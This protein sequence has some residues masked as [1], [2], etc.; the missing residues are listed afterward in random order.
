VFSQTTVDFYGCDIVG[1][2][3]ACTD[4][5]LD[6]ATCAIGAT[7][8]IYTG[9]DYTGTDFEAYLASMN[10]Y[11]ADVCVCIQPYLYC[12]MHS[13]YCNNLG[14][15]V[16]A[17]F[18]ANCFGSCFLNTA[19]FTGA[20]CDSFTNRWFFDGSISISETGSVFDATSTVEITGDFYISVDASVTVSAYGYVAAA[21][22]TINGATVIHIDSQLSLDYLPYVTFSTK[23]QD[24]AQKE[25]LIAYGT[26][27]T[28]ADPTNYEITFGTNPC[29]TYDHSIVANETHVVLLLDNYD[30]SACS[31]NYNDYIQGSE[32]SS[33]STESSTE[34]G[35]STILLFSL[36]ATL[37]S[38]F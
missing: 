31:S 15:Y 4:A 11:L 22:V 6:Y 16:Q 36:I 29:A 2:A 25:I 20:T 13:G 28:I 10:E 18:N 12:W 5:A 8:P 34:E 37:L 9:T 14:T 24:S 30:A 19:P 33:S 3:T 17:Y 32:S 21:T 7:V 27:A 1:V 26:S 35:S 38:F 23:R